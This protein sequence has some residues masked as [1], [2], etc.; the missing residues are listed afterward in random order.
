MPADR[1]AWLEARRRGIGGT[2]AAAI[3]GHSSFATAFDVWTEKVVGQLPPRPT[4]DP[5]WWGTALEAT[6]ARWYAEQ[7]GRTLEHAGDGFAMFWHPTEPHLFATPDRLVVGE[8]RGVEIKLVGPHAAHAWGAAGS[9]VIP[10]GYETQVRHC[11]ACCD[12]DIWDVVA[13]FGIH[14]VRVFTL[15]RERAVEEK[16]VRLLGEWWQRHVVEGVQPAITG[17]DSVG[18]TLARRYP[19]DDGAIVASTSEVD[20]DLALYARADAA[21]K[22]AEDARD[23]V[24]HRIV[25]FMGEA[26]TLEG[27]GYRVTYRSTRDSTTTNWRNVAEAAFQLLG[28]RGDEFHALVKANTAAKPGSRRFVF[29][30]EGKA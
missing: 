7:T 5:M 30:R 27:T 26:A 2:D 21:V 22:L 18:K 29:N 17:A 3:L 8:S 23:E 28:Q 13:M 11:M 9:D 12:R 20:D 24:R 4:T 25:A 1:E 6:I 19:H 10:V 15:Y 16:R 14:D